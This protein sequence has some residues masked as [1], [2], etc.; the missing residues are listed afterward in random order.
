MIN[1]IIPQILTYQNIDDLFVNNNKAR[2]LSYA[3]RNLSID[4]LL[5]D[6]FICVVG[7]PGIGKSRLIDEI[8]NRSSKKNIH[9]CKASEIKDK[10]IPNDIEYCIIDA[11][12]EVE[13][14]TFYSTLQQIKDY[15][16]KNSDSKVLFT[17]RK[18]Y[19][20]SYKNHFASC[21]DLIYVELFD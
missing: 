10:P 14:D 3:E 11:L 8:K 19:V 17:C 7:E 5:K 13:G 9:S 4:E 2:S 16:E 15:K 18:H 12:D 6:D 21:K 1:Y 20:A